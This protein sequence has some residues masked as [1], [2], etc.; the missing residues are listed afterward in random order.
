MGILPLR[1]SIP[2]H[3]LQNRRSKSKKNPS[4]T[5]NLSAPYYDGTSFLIIFIGISLLGVQGK[6]PGGPHDAR[7]EASLIERL[8]LLFCCAVFC[9]PLWHR[10]PLSNNINQADLPR[11]QPSAPCS[12]DKMDL[13][14]FAT[15]HPLFTDFWVVWLTRFG[16]EYQ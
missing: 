15:D 12:C 4:H 5:R 10:G 11:R 3:N 1:R 14:L 7:C 16:K 8:I 13:T 2:S 6:V 9:F